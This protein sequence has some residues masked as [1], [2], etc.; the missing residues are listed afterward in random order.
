MGLKTEM[1]IWEWCVNSRA[2]LS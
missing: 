1:G 2:F